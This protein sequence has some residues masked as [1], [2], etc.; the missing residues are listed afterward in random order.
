MGTARVRRQTWTFIGPAQ[1]LVSFRGSV[2][3]SLHPYYQHRWLAAEYWEKEAPDVVVDVQCKR[4]ASL[5]NGEKEDHCQTV[6]YANSTT[7]ADLLWNSTFGFC[8]G[9]SG[10][11]SFRFG[12]VLSTGG[13]PVVVAPDF[14]PPFAPELDW[15]ACLV[16]VSEDRIVDLPALLRRKSPEEIRER[17]QACWHLFQNVIGDRRE[18]QGGDMLWKS[19]GRVTFAMAMRIWALRISNALRMADGLSHTRGGTTEGERVAS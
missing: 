10:V 13:I 16:R 12:E 3:N 6:R 15:S 5:W 17:Q 9:G 1:W 11:N 7:Y 18:Q 4:V 8:P 19:D 2:Q 14:V